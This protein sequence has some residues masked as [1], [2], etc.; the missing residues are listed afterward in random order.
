MKKHYFYYFIFL[1]LVIFTSCNGQVKN[2]PTQGKEARTNEQTKLPKAHS[3]FTG[4][5]VSCA[6]QDKEGNIWL[7]TNGEGLFRYDGKTFTNFT[8]KDGLDNLFVYSVLQDNASN[9]WVGTKTGLCKYDGKTFKPISFNEPHTSNF[10]VNNN[11]PSKN[12]VWS[13][14]QDKSGKIWL[15]T[16]DGVYYYD[17]INFSSFLDNKNIINKDSLHLKGIF[18]FIEDKKGNIWFGSC[19]GEGLIRFDG[20]ILQRISPKGYA[21]TQGLVEDKKGNIWFASI[22]KGM[23]QYNGNSIMINFF[24]EKNTYDLLYLILKDKND[25]L[26]FSEPT[27]NRPLCFY[28]GNAIH[29]FTEIKNLPDKKIYPVLEDKLG[30]IWFTAEGMGLYKWDG[31]TFIKFSE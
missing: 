1:L 26:W 8:E 20:K 23:C 12:R 18:S 6:M 31:K 28:D 21:R 5:C 15:G 10:T 24:K 22:G 11:P 3:T 4:A 9:I 14:M 7:G 16:D 30:N 2:S 27:N 25:H 19:I 29:S 13:I 17:G